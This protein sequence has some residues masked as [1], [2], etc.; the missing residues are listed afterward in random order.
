V[1]AFLLLALGAVMVVVGGGWLL[2]ALLPSR[3]E[4]RK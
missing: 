1:G 2:V 4:R 3:V